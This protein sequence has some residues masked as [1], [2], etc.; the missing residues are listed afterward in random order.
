[1]ILIL[2]DYNNKK[3]YNGKKL[4]YLNKM[5]KNKKDIRG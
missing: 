1:M 3:D 2:D 5:P 4:L